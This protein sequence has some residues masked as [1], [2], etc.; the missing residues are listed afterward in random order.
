SAGSALATTTTRSSPRS[1][2]CSACRGSAP[3]PPRRPPAKSSPR[4][5]D[6]P[7]API[8][9]ARLLAPAPGAAPR[10]PGAV[11][12]PGRPARPAAPLRQVARPLVA[13]GVS[14]HSDFR[15][16]PVGRLMRT[17]N[18]TLAMVFGTTQQARAAL[19]RVARR[20]RAVRG[21]APSGH[22]YD[23]LDPRLLVW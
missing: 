12:L 2:T 3:R 21:I 1:R 7:P 5:A 17:L 19:G 15:R 13:A 10:T 16:D 11:P 6:A 23:A 9:D 20:H 8:N 18:T 4:S 22:G 14:E